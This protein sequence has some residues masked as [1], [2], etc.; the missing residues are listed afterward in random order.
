MEA[1]APLTVRQ[2]S[3][4]KEFLVRPLPIW[5][6]QM[7]RLIIGGIIVLCALAAGIYVLSPAAD[8]LFY[9]SSRWL[10]AMLMTG[11]PLMTSL[12]FFSS[13]FR[14]ARQSIRRDGDELAIVTPSE[15]RARTRRIRVAQ[16]RDVRISDAPARGH[17]GYLALD[18]DGSFVPACIGWS[19]EQLAAPSARFARRCG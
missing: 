2:T 7:E 11:W 6:S 15:Y 9:G 1:I 5:P 13:A 17:R 10:L 8:W 12:C 19:R 4:S 16:V 14:V 18:L 3:Q